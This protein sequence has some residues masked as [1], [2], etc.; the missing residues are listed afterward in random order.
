MLYKDN[1]RIIHLKDLPY[2]G[3]AYIKI[4]SDG[5]LLSMRTCISVMLK[6]KQDGYLIYEV[7]YVDGEYIDIDVDIATYS[8]AVLESEF[9][10][11]TK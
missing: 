6:G 5:L 10:E 3:K 11:T 4:G 2:V 1:A 8:Y 9:K 7:Q